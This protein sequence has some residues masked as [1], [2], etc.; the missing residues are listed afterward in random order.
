MTYSASLPP[1]LNNR[2]LPFITTICLSAMVL[3]AQAAYEDDCTPP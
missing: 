3:P 1:I 2:L